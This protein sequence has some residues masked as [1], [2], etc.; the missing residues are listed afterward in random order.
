MNTQSY[1]VGIEESIKNKLSY[2]WKNLY[3]QLNSLDVHEKGSVTKK[4]FE[5]ALKTTGVFLSN[6]DIKYL[7]D[8]YCGPLKDA[9]NKGQINYDKVSQEMGLH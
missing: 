8:N 1:S 2:E 4:Q 5:D 9:N 6:E 7:Q 3:R